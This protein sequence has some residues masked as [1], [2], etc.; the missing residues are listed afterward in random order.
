M[1]G[2]EIIRS[3][4]FIDLMTIKT[5]HIK[6]LKITADARKILDSLKN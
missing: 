3:P 6:T 2:D 4:D 1:E 5:K